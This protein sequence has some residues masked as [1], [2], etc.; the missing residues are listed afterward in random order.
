MDACIDPRGDTDDEGSPECPKCGGSGVVM[1]C[2]DD[3]CHGQG[4]C[5]HGDGEEPCEACGGSGERD[6]W[7]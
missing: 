5:I 4:Y 2:C 6:G 3:L 7:S 1:T